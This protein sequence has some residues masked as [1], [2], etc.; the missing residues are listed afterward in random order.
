MTKQ[1][2]ENSVVSESLGNNVLQVVTNVSD[3]YII[4]IVFWIFFIFLQATWN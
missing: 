1:I 2:V 3:S 4:V